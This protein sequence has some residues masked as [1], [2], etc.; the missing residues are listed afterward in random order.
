MGQT[1]NCYIQRDGKFL[2]YTGTCEQKAILGIVKLT[3]K[4]PPRQNGVVP[5]KIT[6]QKIKEHMA[7]FMTDEDS[8]KERDPNIN[9]INGIHNIKGKTPVNVL[10]SNYKNKHIKFN[11]GEN[12]DVLNLP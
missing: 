6:G 3:L 12:I 7:Y 10:V 4:I 1:K 9:S 5:I 8:T 11:K 2:T